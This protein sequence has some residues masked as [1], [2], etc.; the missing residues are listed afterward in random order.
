MKIV[1]I[2]A[3]YAPLI[4]GGAERSV[5]LL[6]EELARCGDQVSVITLHPH[7]EETVETLNGVR[8]YRLPLDNRYWPYGRSERPAPAARLLWHMGDMWN[9]RAAER[10]GQILDQERPDVVHTNIITGFSVSVWRAVKK[11]NIRLVHTLRDY[12]LLCSRSAL[13]RNGSTCSR[14]CADCTALTAN[15]R[16]ASQLVD[17][18]VS[19]SE[20]VLNCHTQLG[21]FPQSASSVIYNIAGTTAPATLSSMTDPDDPLCFGYIGR[22]EEEKGIEV[23]LAATQ[24]L[25]GSH[26]RLRIGGT[27]HEAYLNDLKHR[28]T[29]PRIE[30]LGFVN[31]SE[32]YRSTDVTIISSVWPEPLSRAVIETFAAG[33]SAI[34]AQS[35]GIPEIAKLGKV[36]ATYPARD[37][38]A[39]AG[40]MDGA[41]QD[42]ALWRSG[43]FRDENALNLFTDKSIGTRYREVYEGTA[44]S[45]LLAASDRQLR[46][47]AKE[48]PRALSNVRG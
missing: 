8:V 4:L 12:Y 16:Q 43:G 11:R 47:D 45:A 28:F 7:A 34:C 36:V 40:M 13:F 27:G 44:T 18:V 2:N 24:Y 23:V 10:V 26:W 20:Y 48:D 9:R 25:S 29:D 17:A 30:W 38:H 33:K 19:I 37:P 6:A 22:V 32:F 15:R 41:M 21:Y 5:T 35:G 31:A 42:A 1:I 3:L 39:L 14:R 46:V